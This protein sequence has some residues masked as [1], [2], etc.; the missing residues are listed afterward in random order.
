MFPEG[1]HHS[2]RNQL[3]LLLN[4]SRK[5]AVTTLPA[6]D[7]VWSIWKAP[8]FTRYIPVLSYFPTFLKRVRYG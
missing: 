8:C 1:E 6:G 3:L 7:R 5:H 2:Q 4:K